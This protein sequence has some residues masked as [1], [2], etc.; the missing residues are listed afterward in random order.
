MRSSAP[1]D[2]VQGEGRSLGRRCAF[3]RLGGCNLSCQWCDT[4]YTWDWQGT[5]NA[6]IR[7]DPKVE[8][9]KRTVDSVAK[10]LLAFGVDL[11]VI[12]GGEPLSQQARLLPL[13]TLLNEEGIEVEIETNGT[14]VPSPALVDANVRFNVSPKLSHSGDS[15]DKR[16]VPAALRRFAGIPGAT[17][18]FVCRDTDDLDEVGQL[19][20]AM[21]ISSVWIMPEGQ[22]GA[23]IDKHM[24][25]IADSVIDRGW[26]I[27]TRLHTL[28]WGHKRG[29]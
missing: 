19:V 17:F 20:S 18:K 4:P 14:R 22:D 5:S 16:I 2:A 12:S 24:Q 21:D 29:V 10:E 27:T 15:A 8:L 11:V 28:V 13:V 26:N 23:A 25:N 3:L 9:H 7:Y 1:L 6:G